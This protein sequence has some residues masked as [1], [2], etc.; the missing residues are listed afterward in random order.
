MYYLISVSWKK[1][2]QMLYFYMQESFHHPSAIWKWNDRRVTKVLDSALHQNTDRGNIFWKYGVSSLQYSSRE[3][4]IPNTFLK[5][6][7]LLFCLFFSSPIRIS[8]FLILNSK[9]NNRPPPAIESNLLQETVSVLRSKPFWVKR[10]D[11]FRRWHGLAK[12]LWTVSG[13]NDLA[14]VCLRGPQKA[15][16]GSGSCLGESGPTA[17]SQERS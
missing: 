8:W 15:S 1:N 2:I 14:G 9:D 16:W 12:W 6:F 17:V 10:V 7:M 4:S 13:C 3:L 11:E 5:H